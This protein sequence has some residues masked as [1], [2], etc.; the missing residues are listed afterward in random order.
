MRAML[1]KSHSSMRDVRHWHETIGT[2]QVG[3]ARA[4]SEPVRSTLGLAN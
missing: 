2:L 3:G 4:E 1:F